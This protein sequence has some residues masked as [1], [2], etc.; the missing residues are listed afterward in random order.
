MRTLKLLFILIIVTLSLPKG[1]S[2]QYVQPMRYPHYSMTQQAN[3][4]VGTV[5]TT[6]ASAYLEVGP[7]SGAN[8]GFLPPRLST[9]ERDA[10]ASPANGLMIYNKTTNNFQGYN[11]S[12]WVNFYIDTNSRFITSFYRIGDSVKYV[13][14]GVH[15][16]AFKDSTGGGTPTL[17]QVLTAGSTLTTDH[18]IDFGGNDFI[19]QGDSIVIK[20]ASGVSKIRFVPG[21]QSLGR[22]AKIYLSNTDEWGDGYI[23]AGDE[24]LETNTGWYVRNSIGYN[25]ALSVNGSFLSSSN[26]QTAPLVEVIQDG[27]TLF[28]VANDSIFFRPPLGRFLIDTL[29]YTLSTTGK[30]ILIRDTATGLV[31]N[32]DPSLLGGG[33]TNTS[34]G[35]G[36]KVAI[37]G[38]NN[39]KSLTAGIG[40]NIDSSTSNQINIKADTAFL[41]D[42]S[43]VIEVD[44]TGSI[45]GDEAYLVKATNTV[46][47]RTPTGGGG[48]IGY[49]EFTIGDTFSPAVGDSLLIHSYFIGRKTLV[50]REGEY[51]MGDSA[52]VHTDS[53]ILFRPSLQASERIFVEV[54]DTTGQVNLALEEPPSP[55]SAWEDITPL[56]A[57]SGL[58]ETSTNVWEGGSGTWTNIGLSTKSLPSGSD[59]G[60][61]IQIVN[62]GGLGDAIIG[63]NESNSNEAFSAYEAGMYLS[64]NSGSHPI[65]YKVTNGTPTSLTSV[66]YGNY[67]GVFRE[68]STWTVRWCATKSTTLSDW[69]SLGTISYTGT[70]EMFVNISALNTNSQKMY[71]PQL[72]LL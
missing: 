6:A 47:F 58:T 20:E 28:Q 54:R 27:E 64:W 52:A 22:N 40:I 33:T 29:N 26:P 67:V 7:T 59:G 45:D 39:I 19:L 14:G 48:A 63:F 32:I 5:R 13:I 21:S 24:Y 69:T 71:Y 1:V 16:F 11:G 12:A 43:E 10:I 70:G 42:T 23:T 36:Y 18:T 31:Q 38:T 61:I 68:G 53:T 46:K 2:A 3:I 35:S 34:V 37:D 15:T 51:Q 65:V 30:K 9:T 57:N 56:A 60:L 66:A 55:V 49:L 50:W 8:K 44:T 41:V 17:Q 25:S 72:L 62:P 4:G